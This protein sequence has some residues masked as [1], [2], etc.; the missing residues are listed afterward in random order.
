MLSSLA[1]RASRRDN[2][3]SEASLR[4]FLDDC[5]LF[6]LL[7]NPLAESAVVRIE[8]LARLSALA[9]PLLESVFQPQT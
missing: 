3:V 8:L 6:D 4:F 7:E 1:K 5:D 9:D 2:P